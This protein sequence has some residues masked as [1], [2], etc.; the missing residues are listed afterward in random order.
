MAL[1]QG[2]LTIDV[3]SMSTQCTTISEFVHGGSRRRQR[4]RW[5]AEHDRSRYAVKKIAH[6]AQP[7]LPIA[8]A[9]DPSPTSGWR[10]A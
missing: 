1:G 10:R 8:A 2:R 9:H 6:D 4:H 7:P 5:D 3:A